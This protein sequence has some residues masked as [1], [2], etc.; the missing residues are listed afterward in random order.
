MKEKQK[1]PTKT[2]EEILGLDWTM[3]YPKESEEQRRMNLLEM[4]EQLSDKQKLEFIEKIIEVINKKNA[5][6]ANLLFRIFRQ[7]Q[8]T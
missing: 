6:E 7:C 8:Q 3:F 1:C 2:K 4:F 5:E